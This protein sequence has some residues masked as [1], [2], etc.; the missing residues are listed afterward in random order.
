M[1]SGG[2]TDVDKVGL[3]GSLS[4]S[5]LRDAG[6][7]VLT[8]DARGFGGSTGTVQIDSVEHEARDVGTG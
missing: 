4:I 6:Y 3:L 7:N 5:S 8:W 2:D 1:G